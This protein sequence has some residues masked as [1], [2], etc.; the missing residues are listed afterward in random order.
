[1]REDKEMEKVYIFGHR[2]PDTDS[3]TS[4]IT[5]SYLKNKLGMDTTPAVLSSINLESKYVLQFFKVPEP[6]FL[7]DVNIK[8][9]DLQYTKN[10]T[11]NYNDSIYKAYFKMN[12]MNISKIPV[13]DKD[14]NLMGILSMKDIAKDQFSFGYSY[15]NARYDNICE[16]IRGK[17]I[18]KFDED[19]EGTL[20]VSLINSSTFINDVSLNKDNILIVDSRS[21]IIEY[22]INSG[23]KLIVI[24]DN[25]EIKKQVINSAREK[26]VNI[27][28]TSRTTLET[29]KVFN[30]CNNVTTIYDT[31]KMLCVNENDNVI[32]FIK[33]ANRTR[34]SYYPVLSKR[35]KCTGIIRLSD[36]GFDYKKNV[37]LVDHNSFE[38]SAIGIENANILEIVD[39]HNIG[40]IGTNMP[41]NFRN[42]PVGSTNTIIYL[43]YKENRIVIPRKMAG[44]MLSGILSD[45]LILNSPTTTAYDIEA[46]KELSKI[47]KVN[48][49]KYGYNMIKEGSSI[50]NMTKEQVIYKDYKN[51]TIGGSKVG[52]GQ[53]I[54]VNINE[55]MDKKEEYIKLL[56]MISE[57][58]NYLFVCLFVTNILEN[59]TYVLYSDRA[60]DILESAFDIDEI[61]EGFFLDGV[62]SRKLQILPELMNDMNLKI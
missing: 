59:G 44:L 40:N 49:K 10:Y 21:N 24:T 25:G 35:K 32:D 14:K 5:L 57:S 13:V 39:H 1:M 20:V 34:Y 58:N 47:A 48:Y 4:A 12:K 46:V 45:T 8:I 55:I 60:K 31:T 7:N 61:N 22:A 38:Q 51:Y 17:K 29:A 11:V 28:L 62:I 33:L 23:V 37:I 9:C 36:A 6:I 16:V 30:L 43:L 42:M 56:N 53:I 3:V 26:K 19:I 54:S 18:L 41:I 52:L 2:N 50:K 27:I 15:V